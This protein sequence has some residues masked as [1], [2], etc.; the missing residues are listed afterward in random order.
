MLNDIKSAI[1]RPGACF[2]QDLIGAAA[3]C[4]MLVTTLYLPGLI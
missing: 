3:I 4:V 2:L 1:S